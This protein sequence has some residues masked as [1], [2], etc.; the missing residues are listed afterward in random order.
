MRDGVEAGDVG[1]GDG[2]REVDVD[3]AV[4][5]HGQKLRVA[6]LQQR[7]PKRIVT[8]HARHAFS[9]MFPDTR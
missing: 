1:T 2:V 7:N 6:Y 9:L 3:I 8:R 5:S 4:N